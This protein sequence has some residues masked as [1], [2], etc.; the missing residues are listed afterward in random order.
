MF[1]QD[2][3]HGVS[4]WVGDI[5]VTST[6]RRGEQFS[7]VSVSLGFHLSMHCFSAVVDD[8]GNLVEV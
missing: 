8:F 1:L 5:W 3:L 4:Y 2:R 6:R 7:R